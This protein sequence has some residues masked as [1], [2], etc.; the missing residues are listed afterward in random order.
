M[1]TDYNYRFKV[2]LLGDSKVGKSSLVKRLV[3]ESFNNRYEETAFYDTV[4]KR[5]MTKDGDVVMLHI[6]DTAGLD[7]FDSLQ[8]SYFQ[9]ASGFVIVFDYTRRE[10]FKNV[11]KWIDQLRN[12]STIAEPTIVILGNKIDIKDKSKIEVTEDDIQKLKETEKNIIVFDVSA[13]TNI[14][15]KEAMETMSGQM[16]ENTKKNQMVKGTRI[17][18]ISHLSTRGN[19]NFNNPMPEEMMGNREKSHKSVQL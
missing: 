4:H 11:T 1:S 13:R 6:F 5:V 7:R 3:D 12:R 8:G 17:S 14:N 16:V 19:L 9:G 2:I 15:M 18:R 10:T